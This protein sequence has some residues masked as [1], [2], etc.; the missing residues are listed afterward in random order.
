M[1]H[2]PAGLALSPS[3]QDEA[4]RLVKA[5]GRANYHLIGPLV[6]ALVHTPSEKAFKELEGKLPSLKGRRFS[7]SH[8]PRRSMQPSIRFQGTR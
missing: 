6:S 2:T 8:R 7:Y 1:S 4:V 3:Q 5:A